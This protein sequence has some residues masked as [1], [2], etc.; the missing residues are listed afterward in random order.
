VGTVS[1]SSESSSEGSP[2]K[3]RKKGVWEHHCKICQSTKHRTEHHKSG[4]KFGKHERRQRDEIAVDN[5]REQ[6]AIAGERDAMR[7]ARDEAEDDLYD[8]AEQLEDRMRDL[9]IRGNQLDQQERDLRVGYDRLLRVVRNNNGRLQDAL[10][11][12]PF[13]GFVNPEDLVRYIE[14]LRDAHVPGPIP[15][16]TDWVVSTLQG[17]PASIMTP[18]QVFEE[19]TGVYFDDFSKFM[20]M[21]A[22]YFITINPMI[23]GALLY[24]D[25]NLRYSPWPGGNG[26]VWYFVLAEILF[27]VLI[28]FYKPRIPVE[29]KIRHEFEY[30]ALTPE[31]ARLISTD[32][33]NLSFRSTRVLDVSLGLRVKHRCRVLLRV[34][35]FENRLWNLKYLLPFSGVSWVGC[36]KLC[37][38]GNY[39]KPTALNWVPAQPGQRFWQDDTLTLATLPLHAPDGLFMP[40]ELREKVAKIVPN[41]D[42]MVMD[43]TLY[44]WMAQHPKVTGPDST[45]EAVSL[46]T[47]QS[48]VA[49]GQIANDFNHPS[50]RE[51]YPTTRFLTVVN[52]LGIRARM[53]AETPLVSEWGF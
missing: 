24:F 46:F 14:Q 38:F 10:D 13:L 34:P 51:V 33:R 8:R 6:Q 16:I 32:R 19:R 27:L 18:P 26:P 49:N 2:H 45:F 41:M 53:G 44:S 36:V 48:H 5:A 47:R 15:H 22:L 40:S 20:D 4:Q 3:G 25:T 52:W 28:K 37:V 11:R 21:V 39:Q 9:D 43:L 17:Q 29:V 7:D 31:E 23:I 42:G 50:F 12:G 30:Q 1:E 35:V